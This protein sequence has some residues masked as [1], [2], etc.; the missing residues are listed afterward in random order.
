MKIIGIFDTYP[1][2][3]NVLYDKIEIYKPDIVFNSD[4]LVMLGLN[5]FDITEEL[6]NMISQNKLESSINYL[7]ELDNNEILE[8]VKIAYSVFDNFL[9]FLNEK[10]TIM[11]YGKHCNPM[12][13]Q[14]IVDKLFLRGI[15]IE[16][17]FY[18]ISNFYHVFKSDKIL[19]PTSEFI[20]NRFKYYLDE[21]TKV[22]NFS[23]NWNFTL[24]A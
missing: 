20:D 16:Q 13:L 2:K 10:M 6:Y 14:M 9:P 17:I 7:S 23:Y 19:Y 18:R 3:T 21:N 8:N 5:N 24:V 22:N 15:Y 1:L 11:L 12:F 4:F